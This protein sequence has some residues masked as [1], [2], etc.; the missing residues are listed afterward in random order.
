MKQVAAASPLKVR[1]RDC[2]VPKFGIA[3]FDEVPTVA[4]QDTSVSGQ[5]V[6]DY[7]RGCTSICLCIA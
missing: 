3:E 4:Y 7:P 2:A 1:T 6:E 5:I